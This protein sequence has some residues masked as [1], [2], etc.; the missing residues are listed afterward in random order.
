M[1]ARA[2]PE[3]TGNAVRRRVLARAFEEFPG[4][5]RLHIIKDAALRER[6]CLA[7]RVD[8]RAVASR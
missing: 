6:I 2:C 1:I 5:R 4:W 7:A 3:D 8:E